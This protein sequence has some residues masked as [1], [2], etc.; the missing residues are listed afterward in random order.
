MSVLTKYKVNEKYLLN[1]A[2]KTHAYYHLKAQSDQMFFFQ[3][4][5][6]IIV[7][8]SLLKKVNNLY[9]Y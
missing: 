4:S 2:R 8:A 1:P 3:K 5:Q 6:F 7:Q 9:A